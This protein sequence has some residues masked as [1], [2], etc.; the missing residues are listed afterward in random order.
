MLWLEVHLFCD[1][2]NYVAEGA[3]VLLSTYCVVAGVARATKSRK[4][5]RTKNLV[6]PT[7]FVQV[8]NSQIQI[9]LI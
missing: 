5:L 1:V 4:P 6:D 7:F 2:V 3:S 9:R 8:S